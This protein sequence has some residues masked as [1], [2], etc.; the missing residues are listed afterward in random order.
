MSIVT[1]SQIDTSIS[2]SRNSF[3]EVITKD[4]SLR[5][6]SNVITLGACCEWP[7]ST[8]MARRRTSCFYHVYRPDGLLDQTR[9]LAMCLYW[10]DWTTATIIKRNRSPLVPDRFHVLKPEPEVEMRRALLMSISGHVSAGLKISVP[11]LVY[12]YTMRS[13][14]IKSL[15]MSIENEM[16]NELS[17]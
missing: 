9:Q 2:D 12:E 17:K 13:L 8:L 10:V 4:M 7:A 1:Q 5:V 16:S 6:G 11:N 14:T 15:C 3:R